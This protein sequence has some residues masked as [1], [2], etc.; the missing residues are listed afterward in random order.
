MPDTPNALETVNA[1]KRAH[2]SAVIDAMNSVTALINSQ[3]ELWFGGLPPL[4]EEF[5]RLNQ[6]KINQMRTAFGLDDP[7]T[8]V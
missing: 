2:A 6:A 7:E 1:A 3:P 8:E 4:F 5:G